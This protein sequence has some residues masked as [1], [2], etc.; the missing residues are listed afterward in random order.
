MQLTN[1]NDKHTVSEYC[2]GRWFIEGKRGADYSYYDVQTGKSGQ[3][4]GLIR[5]SLSLLGVPS[6]LITEALK[7]VPWQ[8]IQPEV[9]FR[10]HAPAIVFD[11]KAGYIYRNQWRKPHQELADVSSK[12]VAPFLELLE[13]A[14]GHEPEAV[15]YLIDTLAYRL[16]TKKLPRQELI[17]MAYSTEGAT[18]K[19]SLLL[20]VAEVFGRT[21]AHTTDFQSAFKDMNSNENWLGNWVLLDETAVTFNDMSNLKSQVSNQNVKAN[22][23]GKGSVAYTVNAVPLLAANERPALDKAL[24]RRLL[25]L[26]SRLAEVMPEQAER[27]AYLTDYKH[28]LTQQ[29]GAQLL[30]GWL[31][32]RS[33]A[34]YRPFDAPPDTEAK[35]VVQQVMA[36]GPAQMFKQSDDDRVVYRLDH[37]QQQYGFH[38]QTNTYRHQLLDAG[39]SQPKL[40]TITLHGGKR[41]RLTLCLADGWQW[42]A[43]NRKTAITDGNTTIKLEDAAGFDELMERVDDDIL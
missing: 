14:Y 17:V 6:G 34:Q 23:K 24:A 4:Q 15:A 36:V 18:G 19:G 25:L 27:V 41:K 10:Q 8:W 13:R 38:R 11:K 33:V 16:Q 22:A 30:Y 31:M 32:Q 39:L 28:W 7:L 1:T 9:I 2:K 21:A 37:L 20:T 12:A 26:E 43:L 42:T 29:D 5:Q 40:V 35:R 3:T